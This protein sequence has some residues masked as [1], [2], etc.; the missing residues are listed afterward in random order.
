MN[1]SSGSKQL[2]LWYSNAHVLTADKLNELKGPID[3]DYPDLVCIA[4]VKPKNFIR[5]SSL[6]EYYINGYNLEAI[7]TLA[8]KDRGML[9]YLKKCIQY[10][11]LEQLLFTSILTQEI[12]ICE[13]R[14]KD[15][16]LLAIA[17]VSR[18]TNSTVDNE[19]NLNVLL[20]NTSDKYNANLIVLGDF[21]YP[22]ID[23]VHY[24]RNSNMND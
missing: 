7:N 16:Y 15:S 17:C 14:K 4:E 2:K 1:E 13:L 8:D 11:V 12:I 3:C 21:N 5:T 10:H 6:V 18:S 9:I 19:D 24:S 20:K 23:W 22:R